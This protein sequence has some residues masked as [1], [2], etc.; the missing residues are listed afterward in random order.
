MK[1]KGKA[2]R[3]AT[4]L[5]LITLLFVAVA[6]A[7]GIVIM[8]AAFVTS[9]IAMLLLGIWVFFVAFAL[10]FFRDPTPNV[11]SDAQSIVSPAHGKVDLIEDTEEPEFMGGRCR[12]ISIFLSV[13]DVHVE[14]SPI[15]GKVVLAKHTC[16]EFIS[17]LKAAE[18]R[19]NENLLIG[20]ESSERPGEKLAVRLVA[21]MIARRIVPW[22]KVNDTVQRGERISLIQFGSRCDLYLPLT[23]EIKVRLGQH[24]LGGETVVAVR[25]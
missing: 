13:I 22:V 24:V 17:A 15:S 6:F 18:C 16:G 20:L 12:R 21:G 11:P 8:S 2:A 23:T 1:H 7:V 9:L 14:S 3:A 19:K 5:I 10:Y 25:T 4:K